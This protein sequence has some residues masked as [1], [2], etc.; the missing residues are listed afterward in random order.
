MGMGRHILRRKALIKRI[1]FLIAFIISSASIFPEKSTGHYRIAEPKRKSLGISG[2]FNKRTVEL[3]NSYLTKKTWLSDI[4]YD[5]IPYRPYIINELKKRKMPLFLQYL[6]IV[7]SNYK[8]TAVSHSGA[9]GLWQFMTNSMSPYMKKN[10][11]YDERRDPWIETN[12]ALSKLNDNYKMFKD[13]PLA[14]AAYNM[15]AG[16]VG[17]IC[18]KHPGKD[19]WYLSEHGY[20]TK[21][22]S[23]YVPKLIAIA[24]IIE[25]AE[26][27]G[28]VEVAAMDKMIL[29]KAPERFSYIKIKGCVKLSTIARKTGIPL[30]TLTRLNPAL[31]KDCTPPNMSYR[32]RLPYGKAKEAAQK[33]KKR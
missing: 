16:A 24:D 26:L 20:L 17:R 1:L 6:P 8:P 29:E 22:A 11:F 7:E 5:S 4:L 31:L 2:V 19:F 14:L 25:N 27:Y 28:A 13:W 30:E 21:Q 9:T 10:S 12:A 3:R 33:L 32:L 23:D 18:K 15:G